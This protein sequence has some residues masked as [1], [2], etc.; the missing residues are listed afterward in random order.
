MVVTERDDARTT[1][2]GRSR[3]SVAMAAYGGGD[4]GAF[5]RV[6]D[7]LAPGLLRL[8]HHLTRDRAIAEDVVQL[9]FL[10]MH[11]AR[12]RFHSGADVLPWAR[13][14]TR[15]LAIDELRRRRHEARPGAEQESDERISRIAGG[16]PS[17]EEAVLVH[18]LGRALHLKLET[19]PPLQRETFLLVRDGGL[20]A[21]QAA[22]ELGTTTVAIKLRFHRALEGLREVARAR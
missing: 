16:E 19:L 9:A 1:D 13:T 12:G 22:K 14:I 10:H 5:A 17:G 4:D 18:E 8:A 7:E 21:D 6:Y 3:A 20:R 2:G 15:R 11:L